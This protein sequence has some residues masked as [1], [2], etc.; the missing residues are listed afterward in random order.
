VK[1]RRY[2][3]MVVVG[4]WIE[5]SWRVRDC[6]DREAGLATELAIIQHAPLFISYS[7]SLI[8]SSICDMIP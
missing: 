8:D 3:G 2:A 6:V 1:K 4:R 7:E 5:W